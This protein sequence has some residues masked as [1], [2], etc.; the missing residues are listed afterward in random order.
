MAVLFLVHLSYVAPHSVGVLGKPV[1]CPGAS[2]PMSQGTCPPEC[3]L[4]Q[5]QARAVWAPG[6]RKQE[7]RACLTTPPGD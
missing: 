4:L 5:E 1:Q 7:G 6:L 3:W 2:L